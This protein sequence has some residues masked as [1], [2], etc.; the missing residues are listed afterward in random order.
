[1]SLRQSVRSTP[2]VANRTVFRQGEQTK[3]A[4][5]IMFHDAQFLRLLLEAYITA[6]V[7]SQRELKGVPV[8]RDEIM[9]PWRRNMGIVFP[10]NVLPHTAAMAIVAQGQAA[11]F[12]RRTCKKCGACDLGRE[13]TTDEGADH[14]MR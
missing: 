6:W 5:E 13:I 2:R 9:G 12:L 11:D 3:S 7:V 1:M 10:P 4:G 8:C 14:I